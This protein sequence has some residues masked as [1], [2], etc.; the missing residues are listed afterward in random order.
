MKRL[1]K[2]TFLLG[3]AGQPAGHLAPRKVTIKDLRR[4]AS[5]CKACDLWK[6]ATQTVFGEGN[7]KAT[8]ML[9]GEQPGDHEDRM[10]KPFVG[11]AG[12]FWMK[13]WPK[14]ELIALRFM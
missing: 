9:V 12:N 13:R 5:G 11:P 14:Q 3:R 4:Q 8:I 1:T 6:N 7:S 10:G 2:E